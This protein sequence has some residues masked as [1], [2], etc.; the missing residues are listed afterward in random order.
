MTTVQVENFDVKLEVL[1][2]AELDR[3]G[4][5]RVSL[6]I[7]RTLASALE[8]I[9]G[10]EE[11]ADLL[12]L[13]APVPA[14]ISVQVVPAAA[15][16]ASA[17]HALPV[18]VTIGGGP[19]LSRQRLD[20]VADALADVLYE[21]VQSLEVPEEVVRVLGAPGRAMKFDLRFGTGADP[22]TGPSGMT[23][24]YCEAGYYSWSKGCSSWPW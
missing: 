3:V 17:D 12:G 1:V 13:P 4:I 9:R 18:R 23:Q 14:E 6:A 20:A 22:L 5:D 19:E 8:R 24:Q 7:S 15:T 16:A 11:V 2:A 10:G 21:S